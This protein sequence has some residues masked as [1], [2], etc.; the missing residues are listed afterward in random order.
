MGV[1]HVSL[2]SGSSNFHTA[3][4]LLLSA[5]AAGNKD[6][7]KAEVMLGRALAFLAL[8]GRGGRLSIRPDG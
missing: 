6:A 2:L 1:L 4:H 5:Q 7:Q 8:A 3:S